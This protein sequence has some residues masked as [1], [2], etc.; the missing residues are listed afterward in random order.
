MRGDFDIVIT[1]KMRK[2]NVLLLKGRGSWKNHVIFAWELADVG[3]GLSSLLLSL[4]ASPTKYMI[5][6]L[7]R[8]Q[9]LIHVREIDKC[10]PS[11][12]LLSSKIKFDYHKL[13]HVNERNRRSKSH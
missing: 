8:L 4:K 12:M 5:F 11:E 6:N 3:Y 10:I 7:C 9:R 1:V 2:R 13:K